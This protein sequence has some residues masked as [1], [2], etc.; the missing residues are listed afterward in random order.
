[1]NIKLMLFWIIAII[2][3]IYVGYKIGDGKAKKEFSL[4]QEL[5]AIAKRQAEKVTKKAYVLVYKNKKDIYFAS[6]DRVDSFIKANSKNIERVWSCN[7]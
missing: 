3:A 2:C 5:D 7:L 4:L 6:Q 1:M